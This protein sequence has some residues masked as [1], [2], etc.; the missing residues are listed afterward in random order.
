[1]TP[2]QW[3][4]AQI[5]RLGRWLTSVD[6]KHPVDNVIRRVAAV[7][8]LIGLLAAPTYAVIHYFGDGEAETSS[9][10]TTSFGQEN[11]TVPTAMEVGALQVGTAGGATSLQMTME[12][13][14]Q[15]STIE[16]LVVVEHFGY[17]KVVGNDVAHTGCGG[18]DA[19]VLTLSEAHLVN[20][21]SGEFG[22]H[23]EADGFGSSV[24]GYIDALPGCADSF[25]VETEPGV[26]VAAGDA[27]QIRLLFD[28]GLG[29][30]ILWN[31][32]VEGE[33]TSSSG[34]GI[35]DPYVPFRLDD[36]YYTSYG[37]HVA[38]IAAHGHEGCS[39]AATD[40]KTG[41]RLD[42][43]GAFMTETIESWLCSLSGR[44]EPPG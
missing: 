21:G 41:R 35:T 17:G 34:D 11:P 39:A 42:I 30:E 23:Q 12:G 25:I 14:A 18:R 7:G 1:M 27:E 28:E 5:R 19:Y 31:L 22:V 40:M 29:Y 20:D 4:Q 26:F 13:G 9:A 33:V 2:G 36:E 44:Y 24:R 32:P 43:A 37:I 16:R 15:G 38:G 6:D 8:G 3:I 10:G